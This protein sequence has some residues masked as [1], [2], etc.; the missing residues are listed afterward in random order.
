MMIIDSYRFGGET[1]YP[2]SDYA[3]NFNSGA[4]RLQ[5]AED[6]VFTALGSGQCTINFVWKPDVVNTLQFLCG[7]FNASV[8]DYRVMYARL[9]SSGNIEIV[10]SNTGSDA[11]RVV[12]AH[13]MSAGTWYMITMVFDMTQGAEIDR[14]K[15]YIN[16]S[17]LSLSKN[18]GTITS[19]YTSDNTT[20][21]SV[22]CWGNRDPVVIAD[23]MDGFGHEF[24]LLDT[25]LSS[26]EVTAIWNSGTPINPRENHNANV[27]ARPDMSSGTF[28]GFDYNWDDEIL[29]A[30]IVTGENTIN[31]DLSSTG[32]IY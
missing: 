6:E 11:W 9:T 5:W 15:C 17:A 7:S 23:G 26:A 31:G 12:G 29:G 21:G 24:T 8:G 32:G 30:G 22:F 1:T 25:P 19:I 3:Y 16:G 20:N 10:G 28:D 18:L 13:G 27:V 4:S 14:V 2:V